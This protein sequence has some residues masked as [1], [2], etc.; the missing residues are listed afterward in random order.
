MRLYSEPSVSCQISAW[1]LEAGSGK[2]EAESWKPTMTTLW[3]NR[4]ETWVAR[5][6]RSM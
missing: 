4:E 3:Q 6:L 2:L 5:F 1:K